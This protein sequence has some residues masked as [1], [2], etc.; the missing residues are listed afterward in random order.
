MVRVTS[1]TTAGSAGAIS[2]GAGA[3]TTA[4]GSPP[5]G[6]A[7]GMT[8]TA[9]ASAT[10]TTPITTTTLPSGLS[11]PGPPAPG[12]DAGGVVAGTPMERSS[13]VRAHFHRVRR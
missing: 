5:P 12:R 10:A 1:W 8:Y 4:A 6:A 3:G 13:L 9:T 2:A 7:L 11:R